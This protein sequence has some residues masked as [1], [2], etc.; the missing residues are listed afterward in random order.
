MQALGSERLLNLRLYIVV[1]LTFL[2]WL[3]LPIAPATAVTL[4]VSK[5][6]DTNDGTCDADCSLREAIIGANAVGGADTIE[7]PSGYYELE[8]PGVDD[9]AA[10]GDLDITSNLTIKGKGRVVVDGSGID[11]VFQQH[12]S[13]GVTLSG[14]WITGGSTAAGGGGI[15]KAD[16]TLTLLNSTVAGNTAAANGGGILNFGGT[17]NV[18]NSTVSGNSDGGIMNF[19]G[20]V[21]LTNSTVSSNEAGPGLTTTGKSPVSSITNTTISENI[22][23]GIFVGGNA[24][25]TNTTVSGNEASNGAGIFVDDFATANITDSTVSGNEAVV[26]GGG[27]HVSISDGGDATVTLTNTTVTLNRSDSDENGGGE[28]GGVS[29]PSGTSDVSIGNSII[30][31]NTDGPTSTNPDC[32]GEFT[33]NDHNIIGDA[34]GCTG[35]T[36]PND[37]TGPVVLGPLAFN[38]GPTETHALPAGSDALNHGPAS[39]TGT[40]QRGVARPFGASFDSGAYERASCSGLVVNVVGTNG[41]DSL[42]GT[43]RADGVLALGGN[44]TVRAGAS[45]DKVCGGNGNDKLFGEAG[46]D[47]LLGEAGN[48]FLDGGSGTDVCVGGPGT[49][50]LKSC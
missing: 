16:G 38:G 32:W 12:S 6:A 43:A 33:S 49:N 1:A 35:A 29:I 24:N 21:N 37:D 10:A 26:N 44:D 8:L 50:K 30:A 5:T 48:D 11:R 2:A 41:K 27:I 25:I 46:N 4:T 13:N 28:G 14:L 20:T 9:T 23:G 34:T 22:G 40:D 15:S 19:S 36:Q 18:K 3:A 7:M 31:G 45:Q 39:G 47:K 42:A 17:L